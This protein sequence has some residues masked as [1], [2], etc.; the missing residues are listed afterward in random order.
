[1]EEEE[2]GVILNKINNHTIIENNPTLIYMVHWREAPNWPLP[3]PKALLT[4]LMFSL[5]P[6][7]L[8]I[9]GY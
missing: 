8:P 5:N 2:V 4:L 3:S 6:P 7:L 1:L 9:T